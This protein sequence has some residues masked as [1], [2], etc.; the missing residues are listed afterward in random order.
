MLFEKRSPASCALQML[1][2][3]LVSALEN[4]VRN[5]GNC[6]KNGRDDGNR[7]KVV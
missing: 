2:G 1:A 4:H 5:K 3:L 6:R 7:Q